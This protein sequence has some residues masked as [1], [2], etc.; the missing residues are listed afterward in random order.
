MKKKGRPDFLAKF[1]GPKEK[2]LRAYQVHKSTRK[3]AKLLGCSNATVWKVLKSSGVP[4]RKSGIPAD[5]R[6]NKGRRGS[7]A[8][9]VSSHPNV[10]LPPTAKEIMS[11][12]SCTKGAVYAYLKTQRKL[13]KRLCEEVRAIPEIPPIARINTKHLPFTLL[14]LN[15][16]KWDATGVENLARSNGLYS[17]RVLYLATFGI[18][19]VSGAGS[20]AG[21]DEE[22][23][24][25]R[26]S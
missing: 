7:V 21:R 16:Q 23:A 20:S 25:P 10:V 17:Q 2:I 3:V 9:W 5:A 11:L 14:L 6:W 15:G 22:R 8:I 24:N 19:P 13:F 18:V 1:R 26:S 12:T 4:V